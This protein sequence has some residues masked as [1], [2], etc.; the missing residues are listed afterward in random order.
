MNKHAAWRVFFAYLSSGRIS[1]ILLDPWDDAPETV[2]EKELIF[3]D[4]V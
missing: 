2:V 1:T 4:S 3:T